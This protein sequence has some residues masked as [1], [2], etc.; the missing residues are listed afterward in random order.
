MFKLDD[1]GNSTAVQ[2]KVK[3]FIRVIMTEV[4]EAGKEEA[5]YKDDEVETM[6]HKA[7]KEARRETARE[8]VEMV[9]R[10]DISKGGYTEMAHQ[11]TSKYLQP[12]D[13]PTDTTP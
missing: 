1:Y 5:T 8:I 9:E 10:W 7:H 13:K 12:E 11:I 6:I 2:D 3:S 4:Y